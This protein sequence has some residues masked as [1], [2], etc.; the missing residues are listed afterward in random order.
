MTTLLATVAVLAV[1]YPLTYY[2]GALYVLAY[3]RRRKAGPVPIDMPYG[4]RPTAAAT[5]GTNVGAL[6]W[7]GNTMIARGR[8]LT[9]P[10]FTRDRP[11][12]WSGWTLIVPGLIRT[13]I[14][15]NG[16]E[17]EADDLA[18]QVPGWLTPSA[19][20]ALLTIPNLIARDWYAA[21]VTAVLAYLCFAVAA[22]Y[23]TAACYA[24]L[25]DQPRDTSLEWEAYEQ[26][27]RDAARY[28]NQMD[29]YTTGNR[30]DAPPFPV[31]PYARRHRPL[32]QMD[33]S[34]PAHNS[35]DTLADRL[36]S[37]SHA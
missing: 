8:W 18:G 10:H 29:A 27:R 24:H 36:A 17:R 21:T 34:V 22:M 14:R 7:F 26:G 2:V 6:A 3:A 33:P 5:D 35:L 15:D 25:A 11:D 32:D 28:H 30:Y 9:V 37:P 16:S 23:T 19:A 31:N 13:T 1:L 12:G 20:L 4:Y